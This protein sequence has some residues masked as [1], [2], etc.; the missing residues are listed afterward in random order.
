[1]TQDETPPERIHAISALLVDAIW[2]RHGYK[3]QPSFVADMLL[4]DVTS[5]EAID[6][7]ETCVKS[8]STLDLF[9]LFCLEANKRYKP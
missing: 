5:E 3:F 6:L 8:E 7:G 1:M 2:I 9:T 4:V